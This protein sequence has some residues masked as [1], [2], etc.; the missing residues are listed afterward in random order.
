MANIDTARSGAHAARADEDE[1]SLGRFF[2]IPLLVGGVAL[3][4]AVA[5]SARLYQQS[6]GWWYG[7]DATQPEFQTYW[8]TLLYV[9][10]TI[11]P[12]LGVGWAAFLWFTRDRELELLKPA[13]ELKRYVTFITLVF[14]YAFTFYWA[15]SFFAEQDATWHQVVVRDTSFTPSHIIAFYFMFPLFIIQGVAVLL[16]ATTRLPLYAKGVSI[17]L[18]M[19]VVGPFM[20]LP[21][22]GFNEWGHA[23]WIMEE[24]FTVPLHYGFVFFGWSIL[25]LGG[26]LVQVV[27]RLAVLFTKV[28][29]ETS[30]S[31]KA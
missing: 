2:N 28:F 21:N 10:L 11:I 5:I 22:V 8:M 14:I 23:F 16:Y 19:A 30:Q 31:A 24:Y 20:L 9:E 1:Q 15:G 26:I 13:A 17:P 29:G 25:A 3:I 27:S 18:M 12:L 7:L 4:A 6:F